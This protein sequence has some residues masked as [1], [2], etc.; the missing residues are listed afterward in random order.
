MQLFHKLH[1]GMANSVD[2]GFALFA[3]AMWETLVYDTLGQLPYTLEAV[4]IFTTYFF[5]KNKKEMFIRHP[6]YVVLW[7]KVVDFRLPQT[8]NKAPDKVLLKKKKIKKE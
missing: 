4:R 5:W 7:P 8:I 6:T 1:C 2:P 3:Y